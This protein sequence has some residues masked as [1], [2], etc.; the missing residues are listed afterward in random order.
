MFLSYTC[1]YIYTYKHYIIKTGVT[2]FER[3]MHEIGSIEGH[4]LGTINPKHLGSRV[5]PRLNVQC[6]T[7]GV[8]GSPLLNVQCKT[9]EVTGVTALERT[10]QN[11]GSNGIRRL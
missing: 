8:T 3:S 10:M 9:L 7:L 11:I 2:A 6:K 4:R 5:S 1:F